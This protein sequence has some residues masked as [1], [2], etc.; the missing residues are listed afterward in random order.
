MRRATE[1]RLV[2]GVIFGLLGAIVALSLIG[3]SPSERVVDCTTLTYENYEE[4]NR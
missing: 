4:C 2:I 3:T 1:E